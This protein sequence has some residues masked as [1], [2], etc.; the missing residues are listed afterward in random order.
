VA[1]APGEFVAVAHVKDMGNVDGG[2]SFLSGEVVGVERDRGAAVLGKG[3]GAGA[4]LLHVLLPGVVDQKVQAIPVA[5]FNTEV[6]GIVVGLGFRECRDDG[7]VDH[8]VRAIALNVAAVERV[9]KRHLVYV[10]KERGEIAAAGSLVGGLDKQ[11]FGGLELDGEVVLIEHGEA[12]VVEA[13]GAN[14]AGERGGGAVGLQGGGGGAGEY[15]CVYC[16]GRRDGARGADNGGDEGRGVGVVAGEL[17]HF[18]VLVAETVE[19]AVASTHDPAAARLVGKARAGAEIVVIAIDDAAG[20]AVFAGD[21][22]AGFVEIKQAAAVADIDG[23]RIKVVAEADVERQLLGNLPVVLKKRAKVDVGLAAPIEHLRTLDQRGEA[24]EVVGNRGAGAGRV[25]TGREDGAEDELAEEGVAAQGVKAVAPEVGAHFQAMLAAVDGDSVG[26]MKAV[27][28]VEIAGA[29][30]EAIE[31]GGAGPFAGKVEGNRREAGDGEGEERDLVFDGEFG[32]VF[33]VVHDAAA[34]VAGVAGA[35]FVDGCGRDDYGVVEHSLEDVA[36]ESA[37]AADETVNRAGLGVGLIA[38]G[39]TAEKVVVAGDGVVDP[40]VPLVLIE[41]AGNLAEEVARLH[42]GG[43]EVG[44]GDELEDR[45]G[46]GVDTGLGD[47]SSGE[48]RADDGAIGGQ[49]AG[50]GI[51]DRGAKRRKIARTDGGWGQA[52]DRGSGGGAL[53]RALII[54]EEEGLVADDAA[55]EDAPELVLPEGG[56]GEA[57]GVGEEVIGVEFVVAAPAAWPNSAEKELVFTLNSWTASTLG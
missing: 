11:C 13:L 51:E 57:S 50:E 46:R 23:L 35:E 27:L 32:A 37:A 2:Q 56:A 8:R 25:T 40:D 6:E 17:G 9:F 3:T 54:A 4:A 10:D 14:G 53:A 41:A 5:L 44:I 31:L 43:A 12:G 39:D 34:V 26:E 22:E 49:T 16:V 19:D 48:R 45:G 1:G 55:A 21:G 52:A 42:T 18:L 24:H 36:V 30:A 7:A 20:V 33:D 47:D 29:A 28:V 38:L 15:R